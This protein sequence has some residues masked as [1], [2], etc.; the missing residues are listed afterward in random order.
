[1]IPEKTETIIEL[2]EQMNLRAGVSL[3]NEVNRLL[4]H[5]NR[6]SPI[7]RRSSRLRGYQKITGKSLPAKKDKYIVV[8][9]IF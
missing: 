1:M 8:M 6:W 9:H 7:V 4:G 3:T 5:T 2:S